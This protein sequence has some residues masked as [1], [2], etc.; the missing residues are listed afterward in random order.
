MMDKRACLPLTSS[1]VALFCAMASLLV[2]GAQEVKPVLILHNANHP[3]I[4]ADGSRV[5][6][7]PHIGVAEVY[8][9]SPK[10][11]LRSFPAGSRQWLS[12]DGRKLATNGDE[13]L[14]L[15]D[16]DSGRELARITHGIEINEPYERWLSDEA[17]FS[18]DL[19]FVADFEWDLWSEGEHQAGVVLW[20]LETRKIVRVFAENKVEKDHWGAVFLSPDA[21]LLAAS[22]N[23]VDKPER[24]VTIVW[25]VESGRELLR[26]PFNSSWL[27]ISA[28]GQRLVADHTVS[29][30]EESLAFGVTEKGELRVQPAPGAQPPLEPPRSLTQVWDIRTGKRVPVI[31]GGEYNKATRAGTGALSPDGRLLATGSLGYVVLWNADTGERIAMLPHDG[32]EPPREGIRSVAFSADGRYLVTDSTPTE[33]VKIWRVADLVPKPV[34]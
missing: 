32:K 4:S 10:R 22:R 5:T 27:A 13:G 29:G 17:S 2:T 25:E 28:D 7:A 3:T 14:R 6:V 23:N 12:A 8:Q 30:G 24:N 26:Q 18:S 19:R 9:V 20:D 1:L 21:R 11:K 16:V 15:W 34:H 31:G 33:I